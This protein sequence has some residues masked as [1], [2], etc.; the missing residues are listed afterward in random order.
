MEIEHTV[1]HYNVTAGVVWDRPPSRQARLLIAKRRADDA[2]GGLW[3]FPGGKQEPRESLQ[4]CLARELMEE[5]GIEVEV[6]EPFITVEHNYRDLSITLHTFHCQIV[7]GEPR[8]IACAQCE[9]VS[10]DKLADYSFSAADEQVITVLQ[11][12]DFSPPLWQEELAHWATT[13]Q[14]PREIRR[15]PQP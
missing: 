1:P 5:L 8:A 2:R 9:W 7:R 14:G 3:E 10:I 13:Y 6:Q 15:G 11:K 12:T 4:E